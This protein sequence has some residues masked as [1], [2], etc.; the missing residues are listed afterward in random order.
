MNILVVSP[1]PDDET[2]GAGGSILRF[3]KE[4][5]KVYWLNMTA[6]SAELGYTQE[7]IQRKQNQID[8]VREY[9]RFDGGYDLQLHTTKLQEYKNDEI[10]SKIGKYVNEVKP[11]LIILP[12]YN[13]AHS[14][15]KY[16]FDWCYACT[17]GFRYPS[18]K[19][20]LTMEILSETDFGKPQHPFVPNYFINISDYLNEKIEVMSIYEDEL[21]VHPFPRS[22]E[23]IKALATLRGA[24]AGVQY[25]EAFRV[26]KMIV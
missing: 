26:L 4:G 18:V 23:T 12:D 10:I 21:G 11:E 22:V 16:V 8:R 2:L 19:S 13:D 6:I 9:Y 14:D 7:Q 17:K 24:A 3:K 1:H 5:N 25:A 20:I 15:H